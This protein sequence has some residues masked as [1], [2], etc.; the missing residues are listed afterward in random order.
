MAPACAQLPLLPFQSSSFSACHLMAG[1]PEATD[2]IPYK[3]SERGGS[4]KLQVS[5]TRL[6]PSVPGVC[7]F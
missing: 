1:G 5:L 2:R 6:E 3:D 4:E 7:A